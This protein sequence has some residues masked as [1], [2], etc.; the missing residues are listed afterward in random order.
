MARFIEPG[1]ERQFKAARSKL[2]KIE[3]ELLEDS[4]II[5]EEEIAL[6]MVKVLAEL[7]QCLNAIETGAK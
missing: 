4:P 2:T 6:R 5:V 3:M 7:S 1:I